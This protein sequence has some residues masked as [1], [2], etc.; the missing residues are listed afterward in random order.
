MATDKKKNYKLKLKKYPNGGKVKPII[1]TDPNDPRLKAYDDSL[2]YHNSI[3]KSIPD[4]NENTDLVTHESAGFK[5]PKNKKNNPIGLAL[6]L[7]DSFRTNEKGENI[8]ESYLEVYKKPVQPVVYQA[9]VTKPTQQP[10]KPLPF[11]AKYNMPDTSATPNMQGEYPLRTFYQGTNTQREADSIEDVKG[12]ERIKLQE[13]MRNNPKKKLKNGGLVKYING[14]QPG[15]QQPVDM[16]LTDGSQSSQQMLPPVDPM[17]AIMFV[18]NTV[19]QYEQN[20]QRH[21]QYKKDVSAF[22]QLKF[23]DPNS[24]YEQALN[25]GNNADISDPYGLILKAQ[26][27]QLEFGRDLG[28]AKDYNAL[29][30]APYETSTQKSLFKLG[31]YYNMGGMDEDYATAEVEGNEHAVDPNGTGIQFEGPNHENGGI[32]VNLEPGTKVFSKRLKDVNGKSFAQNADRLSKKL[33]K[34][35]KK[36][37]EYPNSSAI[38]N[39]IAILETQRDE[40]FNRQEDMKMLKSINQAKKMFK[41]GGLAM[42]LAG[43]EEPKVSDADVEEFKTNQKTFSFV[44]NNLIKNR[45]SNNPSV[46][47]MSPEYT[48]DEEF[49]GVNF[50]TPSKQEKSVV[51]A[52]TP[53]SKPVTKSAAP[54]KPISY[55]KPIVNK[56]IIN[57]PAVKPQPVNKPVNTQEKSL[58]SDVNSLLTQK[59]QNP[60]WKTFNGNYSIYSKENSTFYLFDKN[61]KLV[62][63]I[64]GGR[65]AD[66]GDHTNNVEYVNG[67]WITPKNSKTTPT[68]SYAINEQTRTPEEGIGKKSYGF[69]KKGNTELSLH[70]VYGKGIDNSVYNSRNTILNDPKVKE[71]LMSYGCI[72]LPTGFLDKNDD[73][74]NT[75]DSLFITPE[76]MKQIKKSKKLSKGGLVKYALGG[77][78]ED[79]F[80]QE[81]LP[82]G[83]GAINPK[84]GI[85]YTREEVEAAYGV[86][87][88]S[89]APLQVTP[90][91]PTGFNFLP[92]GAPTPTL[93]QPNQVPSSRA[94]GPK[95]DYLTDETPAGATPAQTAKF[96]AG[97]TPKGYKVDINSALPYAGSLANILMK[98]PKVPNYSK[99]PKTTIDRSGLNLMPSKFDINPQLEKSQADVR[100]LE[101]SVNK[102]IS[103]GS[104]RFA[105]SLAA[106]VANMRNRNELYGQKFNVENQYKGDKAR[107]LTQ[108]NS[109][110]AGMD[111][112][113]NQFNTGLVNEQLEN[114]YNRRVGNLG[115]T[116]QG[117]VD[118]AGVKQNQNRDAQLTEADIQ[119]IRIIAQR[120][121][122][123]VLKRMF[124]KMVASGQMTKEQA[125]A[126][127]AQAEADPNG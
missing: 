27:K 34:A 60:N 69:S 26:K 52:P 70:D 42:Y 84:T 127:Q 85:P 91:R 74:I 24:Y 31:G 20:K 122:S 22:E 13:Y 121:G 68:G 35:I 14:G 40:V 125:D 28:Y 90:K 19:Q 59:K 41:N 89:N 100:A 77:P 36:F 21:K 39:S 119:K 113:V 109:Q 112:N 3:Y 102:N 65:G 126:Y 123:G 57:T 17:S 64:I 92:T 105:A 81:E 30:F 88:Q 116:R 8:R 5:T 32:P 23:T 75:G 96:M 9:P 55:N 73:Y 45:L 103:S 67:K 50:Y 48:S 72:N 16:G 53:K 4:Y 56:P 6:N 10:T 114:E 47:E 107:L 86:V 110:Q 46:Q 95:F 80:S 120:Y 25:R 62:D 82:R 118:A 11:K 83:L 66:K 98:N 51:T 78:F 87:P 58:P 97:D 94:A 33:T 54:T 61:H 71:K 7:K 63:S 106:K 99:M 93:T 44:P 18:G 29:G 38:E 108:L 49:E 124:D 117:F 79:E 37:D 15:S 1:V 111:M 115:L 43:G 101:E 2:K 104:G 12:L 76:P